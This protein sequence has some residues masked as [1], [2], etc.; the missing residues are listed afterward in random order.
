MTSLKDYTVEALV[1]TVD[2]L[3]FVSYKVDNLVSE[4]ADEVN[5]TEFR[6]SSVEQVSHFST[7]WRTDSFFLP[8]KSSLRTAL[9]IWYPGMKS[10]ILLLHP[11]CAF[12]KKESFIP[13]FL[14]I[15]EGSNLP[16]DNRSGRKIST[17]SSH[18]DAQVPQALHITR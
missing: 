15:V 7:Y 17:I 9:L 6:V 11:H 2:H 12:I 13:L 14:M 8:F 3:G 1:S 10:Q 16:S 4:K 5:E 18:Q